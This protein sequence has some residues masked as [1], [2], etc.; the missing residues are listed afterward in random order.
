M[1]NEGLVR[2]GLI[3]ES[4]EKQTGHRSGKFVSFI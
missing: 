2:A 4:L 1:R 3:T